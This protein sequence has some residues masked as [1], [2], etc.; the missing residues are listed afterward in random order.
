MG[1]IGA[2][3]GTEGG[4]DRAL[5]ASKGLIGQYWLP[6]MTTWTRNINGGIFVLLVRDGDMTLTVRDKDAQESD[7]NDGCTVLWLLPNEMDGST[8]MFPSDY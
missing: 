4:Y 3:K 6:A 8:L 1:Y 5:A 7:E 2:A